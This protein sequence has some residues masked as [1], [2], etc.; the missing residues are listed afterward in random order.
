MDFRDWSPSLP[1]SLSLTFSLSLS[2]SHSLPLS[3]TFIS[4]LPEFFGMRREAIVWRNK[5]CFLSRDGNFSFSFYML[6]ICNTFA[7]RK[8]R[9]EGRVR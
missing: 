1:L 8:E 5:K 7:R 2:L 4:L 9:K 6:G 3:L